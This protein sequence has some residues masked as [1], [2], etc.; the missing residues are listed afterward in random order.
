MRVLHKSG[1][2]VKSDLAGTTYR[3]TA[4]FE[5]GEPAEREGD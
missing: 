5:P 1:L 3:V 2:R 4:T